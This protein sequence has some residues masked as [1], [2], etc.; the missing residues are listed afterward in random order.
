VVGAAL[1]RAWWKAPERRDGSRADVPAGA[2]APFR[3]AVVAAHTA[4]LPHTRVPLPH[5]RRHA[6]LPPRRHAHQLHSA[7]LDTLPRLIVLP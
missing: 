5:R 1:V 7:G 3:D 4:D 6:L 2:R